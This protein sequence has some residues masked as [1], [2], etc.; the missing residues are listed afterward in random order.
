[1]TPSAA[2][3]ADKLEPLS[4]CLLKSQDHKLLLSFFKIKI[5]KIDYADL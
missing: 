3:A 4:C 5:K 1:M 2:I